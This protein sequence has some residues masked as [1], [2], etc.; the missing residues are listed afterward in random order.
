M[1]INLWVKNKSTG[2]IHQVGTDVHDSID[3]L[4][5]E[6]VY[7]N[8]QSTASTFDEYEWVEAPDID[9]YVSVT[10][11]QLWLNRELVH[12]DIIAMLAKGDEVMDIH[13]ATEQSYRNG[14]NKGYADALGGWISVGERLPDEDTFV[15]VVCGREMFVINYIRDGRWYDGCWESTT[16]DFGITH[17]MA[18]PTPPKGDEGE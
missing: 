11:E 18:L 12:K 15:L 2:I 14:Y 10:P 9:A 8:M 16:C 3:F 5:G 13:T 1:L 7:V 17:W 6:V 4:C